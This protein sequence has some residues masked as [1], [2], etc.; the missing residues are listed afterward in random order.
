MKYD[1]SDGWY[2]TIQGEYLRRDHVIQA[3]PHKCY[4]CHLNFRKVL[5]YMGVENYVLP[6][7]TCKVGILFPMKSRAGVQ[8]KPLLLMKFSGSTKTDLK[9]LESKHLEHK[10][11]LLILHRFYITSLFSQCFKYNQ[12]S[13]PMGVIQI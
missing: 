12:Q 5:H 10:G 6:A 13:L 8:D 11:G 3:K 1:P 2:T 7:N 4:L 9:K